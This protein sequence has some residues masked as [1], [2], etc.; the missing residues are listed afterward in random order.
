MSPYLGVED[1]PRRPENGLGLLRE[2]R[3]LQSLLRQVLRVDTVIPCIAGEVV[4][5]LVGVVR[6]AV[7]ILA[8]PFATQWQPV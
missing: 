4:L 1:L 8:M 2:I 7:A 5:D 6:I 3:Q